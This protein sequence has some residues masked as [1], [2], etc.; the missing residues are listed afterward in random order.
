MRR[1]EKGIAMLLK[2]RY[3]SFAVGQNLLFLLFAK[4]GKANCFLIAACVKN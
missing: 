3:N 4:Q 1:C 2:K